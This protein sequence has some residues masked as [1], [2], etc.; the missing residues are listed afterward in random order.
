M[1]GVLA[2]F[3][4]R[5]ILSLHKARKYFVNAKYKLDESP[6]PY[7]YCDFYRIQYYEGKPSRVFCDRLAKYEVILLEDGVEYRSYL[8]SFHA[9]YF[10]SRNNV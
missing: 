4:Q 8:C 10:K 1:S 6:S 7:W 5:K 9:R 2:E 3:T